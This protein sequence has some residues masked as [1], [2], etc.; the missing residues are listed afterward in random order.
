M[1]GKVI[2]SAVA[3]TLDRTVKIGWNEFLQ[4]LRLPSRVPLKE[5]VL[6]R[7]VCYPKITLTGFAVSLPG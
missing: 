4:T 7:L 5:H 2:V 3:I 6:T 1:P